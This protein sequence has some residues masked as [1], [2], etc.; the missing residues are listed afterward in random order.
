MD[1]VQ[2]IRSEIKTISKALEGMSKRLR[3]VEVLSRLSASSDTNTFLQLL[4]VDEDTY[5]NK[6]GLFVKVNVD[7]TGLVFGPAGSA[8]VTFICGSPGWRGYG[9]NPVRTLVHEE[10]FQLDADGSPRGDYAVDLQQIRSNDNEVAGAL[11]SIIL[12]GEDNRIDP[13]SEYSFVQGAFSWIYDSGGVPYASGIFGVGSFISGSNT[14]A[15]F[16]FGDSH[17]IDDGT[18]VF[19]FGSGNRTRPMTFSSGGFGV[20]AFFELNDFQATANSREPTYCSIIGI[21]NDIV[22]DVYNCYIFGEQNRIDEGNT[23]PGN[24]AWVNMQIGYGT[25]LKNTLCNFAFGRNVKS[26][27]PVGTNYNYGR[28]V[29]NGDG[30]G[31]TPSD[32]LPGLGSGH[33]QDS[34]FAESEMIL[35]WPA[36]FTTSRFIFPI[37]VDAVWFFEA[38]IAG[39]EQ[40]CANSYAW[41]IEGVIEN[42]AGT[43]TL[44]VSTVTN[45]YRDVVTKEWQVIAD[46]ATD[47]LKFQYRDT[48]GPDATDCNIQFLMH[49]SEVG[50]N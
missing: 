18:E 23:G 46:D 9:G 26:V 7:E 28:I 25:F 38:Y 5:D 50:F 30:P 42:A 11:G 19:F 48:V 36:A 33:N 17:N 12:G 32:G 31:S 21:S 41:K 6:A 10:A 45:V 20:A 39:T 43:T 40:N 37:P 44:L 4:D 27:T 13:T 35:S 1:A 16:A 3:K 29:W 15:A 34:L 22:G 8:C 14:Y 47:T 49:T 2:L 24:Q